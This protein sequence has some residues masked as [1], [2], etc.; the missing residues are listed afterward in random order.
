MKPRLHSLDLLRGSVVVIMALDHIRDFFHFDSQLFSPEDLTRTSVALFLTRWVTHFCAPVFIFLAGTSACLMMKR[1]MSRTALSAF[2]VRRG[3]WLVV[4]EMT[5]VLFA[6][7][8]NFSYRYIVWQVIWVIG[9]SMVALAALLYV[10]W[11]ALLAFSVV[12]IAGHNLLDGVVPEQF[13]S[14]GWLWKVLHVGPTPI[15]LAEGHT[16]LMI[17][18]LIPWVGV[19]S[20]GFCFGRAFD[21]ETAQ[22][23]RVLL[24]LGLALTVAFVVL[25]LVNM[26]G[27]PDPWSSQSTPTMTFLSF[28]RTTKYPPSLLY[29]LM[30]LGPSLIA[31]RFLDGISVGQR[32]PLLVFGRVPFFFYVVH[33]YALHLAALLFAWM[34]YGRFD[35]LFGLP[36]SLL[37][38]S[39]G[40]PA[41]YG[42]A[43]STVLV[44]WLAIVAV[45]YP[46]C[47][48]FADVKARYRAAWLSYV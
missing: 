28:L 25:R 43:L 34:R 38:F 47:R 45:L 9:W 4:V 48:W 11:R 15:E 5:F 19:M 7:T 46:L 37:P 36:P 8:F 21:L 33:W 31:L 20:A 1:G 18:P 42:Y 23:R 22:R 27:D 17:Y 24:G 39:V 14:L 10:P 6:A 32:N 30:T 41:D 35:F 16:V 26:F 13:G 29:L 44:I 3:L 2:L 12:M 40:Y